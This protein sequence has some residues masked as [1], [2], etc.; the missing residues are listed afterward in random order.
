MTIKEMQDKIIH[1]YGFE[2]P[3]TLYFFE[4]LE[5]A[6]NDQFLAE[7]WYEFAI[8]WPD[9]N[10]KEW[11]E[12]RKPPFLFCKIYVKFKAGPSFNTIFTLFSIDKCATLCYN[13]DTNEREG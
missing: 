9:N 1:T 6:P 5:I 2:H 11:K 7:I 13:V 8:R 12:G 3:A 10:N 4:C